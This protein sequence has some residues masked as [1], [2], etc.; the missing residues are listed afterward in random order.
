MRPTIF[1]TAPL[2]ALL[3]TTPVGAQVT[4]RVHIDIPIGHRQPEVIYRPAPP[5]REVRI[6]DYNRRDD[7][8]WDRA[9]AYR[10]WS[11]MTVYYFAGR[12]YERPIRGARPMVIYRYQ[13]RY[14]YPPRDS[15]WE[16]RYGRDRD[17]GRG[18]YRDRDDRGRGAPDNRGRGAR[19]NRG[20]G[21]FDRP[22]PPVPNA[23]G[24]RSRPGGR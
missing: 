16:Q 12:Y 2:L 17:W 15:R 1:A 5:P 24:G 21:S 19:D 18:D 11:P 10:R 20:Q 13:G 9:D 22:A 3:A 14:F 7:G 8:D 6:Y 23:R 4:A